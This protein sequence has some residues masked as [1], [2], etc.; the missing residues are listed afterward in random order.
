[1]CSEIAEQKEQRNKTELD[2]FF[3]YSVGRIPFSRWQRVIG[4]LFK[5]TIL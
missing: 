2:F 1:M 4:L 3:K 5:E